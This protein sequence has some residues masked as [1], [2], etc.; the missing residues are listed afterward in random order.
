MSNKLY[1]EEYIQNAANAIRLK[2]HRDYNFCID[3]FEDEIKSISQSIQINNPFTPLVLGTSNLDNAYK[4]LKAAMTYWNAKNSGTEVF[5]YSDGNGCLKGGDSADLHDSSGNA[6]MDC[7]TYIG[8]VLRGIDYLK[9]PYYIYSANAIDPKIVICEE[10]SWAENYFDLQENRYEE[11]ALIFPAFAY[12]TNDGLY[13]ILTA[14]D[15]AQYYDS[16]GLFWYA[17]DNKLSPRVGDI[18]FFYKE[19]IASTR[20]NKINHIGIMTDPDYYLNITDYSSSGN[21][22]RTS[23]SSRTPFAYARP[24]YG[25]LTDG[26]TDSLTPNLVD[27]IPNVISDLPQ[28]S[29]TKNGVTLTVNGKTITLSG[30]C[31]SGFTSTIINDSCPLYLPPGTYKLSGFVNNTGTNTVSATHSMWGFRVYNAATGNGITGITTSSNGV[32]TATRTPCWD[33]G[34][35]CTFTLDDWTYIYINLWLPGNKDCSSLSGTPVLYRI[36]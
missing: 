18:C 21:L 36:A 17:E 4:A 13:R 26:I 2:T 35:G 33:I 12:K 3:A 29:T 24:Y 9:S 28:G 7:S 20:F 8:L 32:N 22:I 16:L 19:S 5:N 30:T 1:E 31:S 25:A 14:S 10:D 6:I 34:A 11:E 15:I 27:L 23:V